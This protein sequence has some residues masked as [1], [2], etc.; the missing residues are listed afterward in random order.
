V[1]QKESCETLRGDPKGFQKKVPKTPF[2]GKLNAK[3]GTKFE[4]RGFLRE[5]GKGKENWEN[6][7]RGIK[8]LPSQNKYA[9]S[10]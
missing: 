8:R 10:K 9:P 5:I 1:S 2:G 3:D 6:L 7:K 4:P